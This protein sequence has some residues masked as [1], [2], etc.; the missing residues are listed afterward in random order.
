MLC[1]FLAWCIE[2]EIEEPPLTHGT[3]GLEAKNVLDQL[4]G[5]E[6]SKAGTLSIQHIS[7]SAARR[8]IR[9][10]IESKVRL[11]QTLVGQPSVGLVQLALHTDAASIVVEEREI[12]MRIRAQAARR[13]IGADRKSLLEPG[14]DDPSTSDP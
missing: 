10:R 9:P 12:E 2:V 8:D 13:S 4:A 6:A 3:S 1:A 14:R 7:Q 5:V 11:F